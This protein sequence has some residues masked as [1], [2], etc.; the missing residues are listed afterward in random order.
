MINGVW[1]DWENVGVGDAFLIALIAIAI[2][3]LV[4]II[5]ILVTFIFQKGINVVQK[6]TQIMPKK[7]NEI[8]NTDQDA[9]VAA[10]VATIEFHKETGKDAR[11]VSIKKVED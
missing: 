7:E 10:L 3:F 4:L 5:I 2:V 1:K 8:L 6:H 9:V 11:I